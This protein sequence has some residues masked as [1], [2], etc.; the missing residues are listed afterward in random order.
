MSDFIIKDGVLLSYNGTEED[1]YVP[2]GVVAIAPGCF[3]NAE[4][5]EKIFL[6]PTVKKLGKDALGNATVYSEN[7]PCVRDYMFRKNVFAQVYWYWY[8]EAYF[9]EYMP[10]RQKVT[11]CEAR[12]RQIKEL[13]KTNK[14]ENTVMSVSAVLGLVADILL[15]CFWPWLTDTTAWLFGWLPWLFS[16]AAY[17][18]VFGVLWYGLFF[19]IGIVGLMFFGEDPYEKERKA[20]EKQLEELKLRYSEMA[21][22]V[23]SKNRELEEELRVESP[24]SSEGFS[25]DMTWHDGNPW[26]ANHSNARDV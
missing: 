25:G 21:Q 8:D 17:V 9:E 16:A 15:W 23:A 22:Y 3:E 2:D 6:P 7:I 10:L 11:A 20:L 5:V 4:H 13:G 1:V 18:V 26:S 14:K 19:V 24:I 12:L